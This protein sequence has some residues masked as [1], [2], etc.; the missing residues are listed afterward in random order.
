MDGRPNRRKKTAFSKFITVVYCGRCLKAL[1]ELPVTPLRVAVECD[2]AAEVK[3]LCC[4]G[5]NVNNREIVWST[6]ADD[7]TSSTF[8][9]SSCR[10]PCM[11]LLYFAQS[12]ACAK[13]LLEY[14][15]DMCTQGCM[16]KTPVAMATLNGRLD[17]LETLC[18][19]GAPLNL[20]SIWGATPLIYA[21]YGRSK[22][23]CVSATVSV[24]LQYS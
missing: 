23:E 6:K 12:A 14:E 16:G 19:H 22:T 4:N 10:V 13:I 11:T 20:A 1:Y 7:I 15:V 5:A 2:N 9:A 18:H 21:Q 24:Q 17:V 8:F 3:W